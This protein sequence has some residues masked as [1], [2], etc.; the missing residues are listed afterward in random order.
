MK[1]I[2]NNSKTMLPR[3][4]NRFNGRFDFFEWSAPYYES[5]EEV[6]MAIKEL[7][8]IGKTIKCVNVIGTVEAL[9]DGWSLCSLLL[10]AG[11]DLEQISWKDYPRLDHIRAPWGVTACEPL[12][13][14]FEDNTTFEILPIGNGGARIAVNSIPTE[15]KNGLNDSNFEA[16]RFFAELAGKTL[17]ALKIYVNTTDQKYIEEYTIKN[18]KDYHETKTTYSYRFGFDYP[19]EIDL[20]Q[21]FESYYDI[22]MTGE[23]GAYEKTKIRY[24]RIKETIYKNEKVFIC[25]G[26]DAGGTVWI[27]AFN[28]DKTADKKLPFCDNLGMSIDDYYVSEYLSDFLNRYYEPEIQDES[29]HT[30]DIKAFDWY[31]INVYTY[32]C[33]RKMLADIRHAAKLLVTDY[34]NPE[35]IAIKKHFPWCKYADMQKNKLGEAENR[36]RNNEVSMAVDFYNRFVDRIE[37]MMDIPGT[38][39]ISFAGP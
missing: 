38:N 19:Y 14:V 34:D 15:L 2:N 37:K 24:K 16:N 35:L 6:V 18:N 30:I 8:V 12:Q 23:S 36:I 32:D 3:G 25:N 28:N 17:K 20:E 22:T 29:T 1:N 9:M 11:V 27:V 7:D 39:M 33:I 31:G 10:D 21:G 4:N 5:P 13:F 26:R